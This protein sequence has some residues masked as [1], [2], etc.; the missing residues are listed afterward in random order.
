MYAL[1]GRLQNHDERSL[2]QN[3]TEMLLQKRRHLQRNWITDDLNRD[4]LREAFAV[5]RKMKE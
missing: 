5:Y 4:F 1:T 3:E 2:Q